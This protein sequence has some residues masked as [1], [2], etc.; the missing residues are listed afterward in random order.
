MHLTSVT[1]ASVLAVALLPAVMLADAKEDYRH[2]PIVREGAIA[3]FQSARYGS[4]LAVYLDQG[5][6]RFHENRGLVRRAG[7]CF[8][9]D[10]A[11]C[12]DAANCADLEGVEIMAPPPAQSEW[13]RGPCDLRLVSGDPATGDAVVTASRHDLGD[14]YSYGYS[15]ACG[16]TWINFSDGGEAGDE[17]FYPEGRSLF[18]TEA[19]TDGAAMMPTK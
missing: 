11:V 14:A 17:V 16:V 9:G 5:A 8:G 15:T 12:E 4:Y 3:L 19:C 7:S 6:Y 1:V 10:F 2:N 13:R 18:W